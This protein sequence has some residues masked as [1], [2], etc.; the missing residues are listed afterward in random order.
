MCLGVERLIGNEKCKMQNVKMASR[1]AF[2]YYV[3]S[4]KPFLHSAFYTFHSKTLPKLLPDGE[5]KLPDSGLLNPRQV[6]KAP[7]VVNPDQA[8]G[9]H[10]NTRPNTC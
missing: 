10:E 4:A 7:G 1:F 5:V 3:F 2:A 6:I 8:K 9:R